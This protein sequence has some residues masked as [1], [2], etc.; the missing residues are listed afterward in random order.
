MDFQDKTIALAVT[1]SIAAYRAADMVRELYRRGAAGV[2]VLMSPAATGF[3]SPMTLTMLS[4]GAAYTDPM[5]LDER[6]NPIHITLA[7]QCHALLI[8]PA[9]ANCLAKL[10]AGFADDLVS[11]TALTFTDKPVVLAPAMNTRMWRHP[12]TQ[13]HVDTL[14]RQSH[15]LMIPPGNGQLACGETGDGHLP[16]PDLV[17]LGLY[18]MLHPQSGLLNGQHVLVT[19]GGTR[20]PIDPVR[21]IGNRSSGRMG[22]ALADEAYAM[23]AQVTLI[24]ANPTRLGGPDQ[25]APIRPY[26]ILVVET[27]E[28][29]RNNLE[30]RFSGCSILMMAAAVS[31]YTVVGPAEHKLK[32]I[33]GQAR[34]LTLTPTLDILSALSHRKR[35]G[36]LVVGF[37]AETENLFQNAREKLEHKHLDLIIANDI[38][39]P[40]IG[41]DSQDNEVTLLFRNKERVSLAR[42]SK[43][44]IA[45]QIYSHLHQR[46]LQ[47]PGTG[48]Q[49]LAKASNSPP[50]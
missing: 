37:A 48:P 46:L 27:A 11:T 32:R 9:T 5:A 29:L 35:A 23:G 10:A 6:G 34:E 3:I 31:D 19:A 38:S 17:L 22:L 1:G 16:D 20:E 30:Q 33:V 8:Y 40:D 14:Q 12:S 7:Q 28:Q 39:R 2:R 41:F 25:H 50:R 47:K 15:V 13:R 21:Y 43:A 44:L 24:L 18:R 49:L 42:A 26:P 36:Q 4:Q 45:R